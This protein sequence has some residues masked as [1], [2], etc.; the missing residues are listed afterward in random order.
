MR[1][2]RI[3]PLSSSGLRSL[4]IT[5]ESSRSDAPVLLFLHGMREAGSSPSEVPKVCIHQSPPWRAM[6]GRIP[7]ALVIAPQAPANPNEETWNWRDHATTVGHFLKETF[8]GRRLVATGFSRGGLGVLQVLAAYPDLFER[9]AI[10]DPQ[11]PHEREAAAIISAAASRPGWLRYGTYRGRSPQWTAFAKALEATVS[12]P[13]R[14]VT[15]LGHGELALSAY[16][17][18]RLSAAPKQNLYEFLDIQF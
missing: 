4:I 5:P 3:E 16:A 13:N 18:D 6:M 8:N 11:P 14:D 7:D 2:V 1:T 17:G 12:E 9:W 10:A 15:S